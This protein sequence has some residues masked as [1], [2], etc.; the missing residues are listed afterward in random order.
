MAEILIIFCNPADYDT[1]P[2][3]FFPL[4]VIAAPGMKLVQVFSVILS[5]VVA[6]SAIPNF[7]P[8]KDQAK[9]VV[10]RAIIDTL[11]TNAKRL[12]VGLPPLPA[13]RLWSKTDS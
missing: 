8:R 2:P 6:A 3:P 12:A 4:G 11:D 1:P 9:A 5:L 13:R 7:I 10:D